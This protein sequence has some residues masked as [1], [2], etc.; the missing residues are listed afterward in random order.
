MLNSP[1]PN[2]E[3]K[4]IMEEFALA[5]LKWRPLVHMIVPSVTALNAVMT[6]EMKI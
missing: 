6:L 3:S 1:A 2:V 5:V 4:M